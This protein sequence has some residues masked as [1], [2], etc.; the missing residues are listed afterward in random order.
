MSLSALPIE[1]ICMI[2]ERIPTQAGV[3]AFML[4]H[5]RVSN[6]PLVRE[7]LYN[8][9]G[10]SRLSEN[11]LWA[12]EK[13]DKNLACAMLALG[14]DI[15]CSSKD[16]VFT[17]L[18][19][20]AAECNA[21]IVK[22]LLEHDTSIINGAGGCGDTALKQAIFRGHIEIVKTLLAQSNL[23]PSA[24]NPHPSRTMQDPFYRLKPLN[25]AL[26]RGNEEMVRML[27]EDS[28]FKLDHNS[29]AAA[30]DG[31]NESL[32]KLC[33]QKAP[34]TP[35]YFDESPVALAA[36]RGNEAVVK[37]LLED[38]GLD[39][40]EENKYHRTP[41]HLAAAGGHDNIAKLLLDRYDVEP[42]V[43]D[44]SNITPLSD[45]ARYGHV[46]VLKLLLGSGKTNPNARDSMNRTPLSHAAERGH[47]EAA[48]LLLA[49]GL[50]DADS[51]D[52]MDR[53]PLSWAAENGVP[54]TVRVLLQT[55]RV[56][57]ESKDKEEGRT[58]LSYAAGSSHY[59]NS[60]NGAKRRDD[61]QEC[62][63]IYNLLQGRTDLVSP[64]DVQARQRG[65]YGWLAKCDPVDIIEQ[66]LEYDGV[67]PDAQ[68][69]QGQTPLMLA[70]QRR[71]VE[72]VRLLM[73][74]G[75]VNP[76]LRDNDGW[77][78]RIHAE[79]GFKPRKLT[80]AELDERAW[81]AWEAAL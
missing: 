58:P 25:E 77:T 78:P 29:L 49:T 22:L 73:A 12:C 21:E 34:P 33:L 76:E 79:Q 59:L 67:N 38:G 35:Q 13:D 46:G 31:G 37:L 1:I 8:R 70:A 71:Q 15:K 44:L 52:H 4:S 11:L 48:S 17:P 23:D 28:R 45:A 42:D 54:D 2:V 7:C 27:M 40:N 24:A 32:V 41:L 30:A 20:A 68:D 80:Q 16:Q 60:F 5:R 36:F 18:T 56:N 55:G 63:D 69:K 51:K 43:K 9:T 65:T 74:T 19:I 57:P 53:T 66:L 6:L 3:K 14:A 10:K 64:P 75:K 26:A 72:A 62:R 47:S 50:V 39:P 61:A 81:D